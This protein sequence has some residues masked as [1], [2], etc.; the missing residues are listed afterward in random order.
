[1]FLLVVVVGRRV[2]RW[3]TPDRAVQAGG[4]R[5]RAGDQ[6]LRVHAQG[7][8]W[9]VLAVQRQPQRLLR[10]GREQRPDKPRD[11]QPLVLSELPRCVRAR[12]HRAPLGPVRVAASHVTDGV[13]MPRFFCADLDLCKASTCDNCTALSNC[14]W[15]VSSKYCLPGNSTG[16]DSVRAAASDMPWNLSLTLRTISAR[17]K[18]LCAQ[19]PTGFGKATIALWNQPRT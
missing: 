3:R 2:G 6:L 5:L 1:M 18:A 11:L 4:T 17:G 13:A 14:G 16:P 10:P 8:L 9:V 19:S 7:R 12:A 15:C